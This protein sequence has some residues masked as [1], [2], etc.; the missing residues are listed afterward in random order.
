MFD[1]ITR[2]I[3]ENIMKA[4]DCEGVGVVVEAE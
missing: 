2:E 3:A 4:V 1:K